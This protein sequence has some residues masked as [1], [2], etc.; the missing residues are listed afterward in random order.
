MKK[1]ER[2]RVAAEEDIKQQ[3][4]LNGHRS[5][6]TEVRTGEPQR[7]VREPFL[8]MIFIDDDD[9]EVI[10]EISVFYE[11]QC[12]LMWSNTYRE[13]KFRVSIPDE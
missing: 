3:V 6:W 11:F 12:K 7:S 13:K 1:E 4:Q 8:F 5:G 10:C 9:E 2:W